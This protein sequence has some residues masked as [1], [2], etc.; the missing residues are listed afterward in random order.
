ME[1]ALL[2]PE[3][4]ELHSVSLRNTGHELSICVE[5]LQEHS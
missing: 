1:E 4:T 5:W 2:Q 3:T